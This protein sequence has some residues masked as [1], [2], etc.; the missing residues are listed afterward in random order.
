MPAMDAYTLNLVFP[1]L[2][3]RDL[4]VFTAFAS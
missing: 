4:S 2:F 3:A 1:F